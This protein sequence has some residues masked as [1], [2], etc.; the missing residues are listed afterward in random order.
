MIA[1]VAV[2][3][4]VEIYNRH[5][6]F[7]LRRMHYYSTGLLFF[8]VAVYAIVDGYHTK[9]ATKSR[10]YGYWYIATGSL[11]IA[12]CGLLMAFDHSKHSTMQVELWGIGCFLAFWTVQTAELWNYPTRRDALRA[13]KGGD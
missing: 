4:V 7:F 13:A 9:T 1:V 2:S 12:G 8:L 6:E 5:H 3:V 11:L 10:W